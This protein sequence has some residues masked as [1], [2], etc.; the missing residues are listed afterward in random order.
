M[1][2]SWAILDFV[3][4]YDIVWNYHVIAIYRD[5]KP[6]FK[7]ACLLAV[8]YNGLFACSAL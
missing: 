5:I 6:L 1:S 8:L 7:M 3:R 2:N 4:R